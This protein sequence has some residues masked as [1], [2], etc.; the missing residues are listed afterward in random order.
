MR[1]LTFFALILPSAGF[2]A[3][4]WLWRYIWH[5]STMN[6]QD[7]GRVAW[8]F[9]ITSPKLAEAWERY[10]ADRSYENRKNVAAEWAK[11]DPHRA[12]FF[13]AMVAGFWV[14]VAVVEALCLPFF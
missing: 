10:F 14:I 6:E 13:M 12:V 5:R 4:Q 2:S 3:L 9:G 8:C 11:I 1:V 7:A